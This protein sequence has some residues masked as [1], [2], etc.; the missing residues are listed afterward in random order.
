MTRPDGVEV[1]VQDLLGEVLVARQPIVDTELGVVGYELRFEDGDGGR[2]FDA[3]PGVRA[4]ATILVDG[5]LT[6]GRQVVTEGDDAFLDVPVPLLL[7]GTLLDVP[8]DG[9]VLQLGADVAVEADIRGAI[10][11]HR[12]AGFRFALTGVRPDDPRLALLDLVE[13]VKIATVGMPQPRALQLVRRLASDGH[14]VLA[15]D[16]EQPASFDRFL[17]AGA[18]LFQGFFFTRPRA[19]RAE[20]PL[21][22]PPGHLAL[23]RELALEEVDLDRIEEL[24][25]NDLTLT[26][27]FLRMVQIVSGWQAVESIRHGLVLMGTTRLHRWVSLLVMSAVTSDAPPELLVTASVRARYCEELARLRGEDAGL[28]PFSLGMFSVLGPDGVIARPLLDELPVTPEVRTALGGTA[29]PERSL[30][31]IALGAERAAWSTV[32]GRGRELGIDPRALAEAHVTALR[33]SATMRGADRSVP[34]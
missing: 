13:V 30:L 25:R 26:D 17:G 15:E 14:A 10:V 8:P 27:R 9:L 1:A 12:Q 7:A 34:A 23:L 11:A 24:I 32:V 29:G 2:P 4:T 18:S 5:L 19:V 28:E 31:E 22:L 6:L 16:I 3:T 21:G 20:R 33:W